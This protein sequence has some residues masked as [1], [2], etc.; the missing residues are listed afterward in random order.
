[1]HNHKIWD[2]KSSLSHILS[3]LNLN[4]THS[5]VLSALSKGVHWFLV[6]EGKNSLI[7]FSNLLSYYHI[8]TPV[9]MVFMFLLQLSE[10]SYGHLLFEKNSV[11]SQA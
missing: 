11:I 2:M 7:P 9:V 8:I 6:A 4:L 3:T 1:M 5:Q 10:K